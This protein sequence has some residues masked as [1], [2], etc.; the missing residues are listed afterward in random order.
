MTYYYS[1]IYVDHTKC[2]PRVESCSLHEFLNGNR[3]EDAKKSNGASKQ[4]VA[5]NARWRRRSTYGKIR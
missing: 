1:I 5:M 3:A 2:F 4:K